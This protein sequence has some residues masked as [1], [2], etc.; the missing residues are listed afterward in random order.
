[1]SQFGSQIISQLQM[2]E[3]AR[4]MLSEI[5]GSSKP[6]DLVEEFKGYLREAGVEIKEFHRGKYFAATKHGKTTFLLA[7]ESSIKDGWWGIPE[8]H[9]KTLE[10][11]SEKAGIS[12]WGAVLVHKASRRGYWL[13]SENLFELIDIIP[14]KPDTQGK[15][16]FT[17]DLLDSQAEL[18]PPFFNIA[19]FLDLAGIGA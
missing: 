14:L 1:M 18:A 15:Y 4:K 11:E 12:N 8:E 7:H 19:K 13:S 10:S 2:D 6:R 17:S 16:H 3:E 5:M 9:I